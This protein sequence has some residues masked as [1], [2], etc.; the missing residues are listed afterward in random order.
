MNT[1]KDFSGD[2]LELIGHGPAGGYMS[3]ASVDYEL[4]RRGM[5]NFIDEEKVLYV[6]KKKK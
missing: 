6:T 4:Y 1:G 5:T 3:F 2:T